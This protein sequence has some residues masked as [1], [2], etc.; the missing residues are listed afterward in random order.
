V[1]VV[2]YQ[3]QLQNLVLIHLLLPFPER[4]RL[5]YQYFRLAVFLML[6]WDIPPLLAVKKRLSELRKDLQSA[7]KKTLK[8]LIFTRLGQPSVSLIKAVRKNFLDQR[9]SLQKINF[10]INSSGKN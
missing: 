1:V 5:E 4:Y 8:H 9:I 10:L 2:Y 3:V 6:P 7:R